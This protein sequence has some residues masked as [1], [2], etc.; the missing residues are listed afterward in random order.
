MEQ[1][2]IHSQAVLVTGGTGFAGRHLLHALLEAGFTNLH[3]SHFGKRPLPEVCTRP[4][5]TVHTVDLTDAVKVAEFIQEVQPAHIYHLASFAAVGKSFEQAEALLHNNIMLQLHLLNAVKAHA[6]QA[7]V[8]IIGSAEEYGRVPASYREK[9]IDED[10]PFNPV[11]PYAVTKVTQDLLAQAFYFSYNLN[12]VRV[13]PF[14]HIGEGQTVEFVVPAFASQ[15][16]AVERGVQDK[17]SVG[18]LSSVRDFTDV[19]DMVKAY[20]TLMESGKV[21]DVYNVGSGQ[22][23]KIREVLDMLLAH[24]TQHV[25][26]E[27]D[28]NR[29]RPSDVAYFVADT[30]KVEQ[31]GW[32]PQIPIEQT[33]ERILSEWREKV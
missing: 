31:L 24:S 9:K 13:R 29:M 14:N 30:T 18:N 12:I 23:W 27:V 21:G 2:D 6:P 28:P 15:I 33:L 5:V 4:E 20:M 32:K 3:T 8:L 19:K 7:R 11:N 17:I 26:V 1:Q 10:C 16:V 22:G 25:T